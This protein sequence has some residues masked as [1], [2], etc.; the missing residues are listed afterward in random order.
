MMYNNQKRVSVA[1]T[2]S[3]S[4]DNSTTLTP[5]TRAKR[6]SASVS[7]PK[8]KLRGTHIQRILTNFFTHKNITYKNT[9][10]VQEVN[11]STYYVLV[12]GK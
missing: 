2:S 3:I 4:E 11:Y 12:T 9:V 5:S 7:P 10:V 6:E 8:N 1:E